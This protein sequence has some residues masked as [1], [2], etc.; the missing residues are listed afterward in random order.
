VGL[1]YQLTGSQNWGTVLRG[2]FGVFYDLVSSETGTALAFPPFGALK[3]FRSS[4]PFGAAGSAPPVIPGTGTLPLLFAFNPN[5][6]LPYTLEWNFAV[7]QGLGRQQMIS[8][9]YIGAS[10]RRLLQTTQVFAPPS[11]PTVGSAGGAAFVDNTAFSS[12]NTLQVQFQ[13]RLSHGLQVLA[14]YGWAHSID[15]GSAGSVQLPSNKGVP[16]SSANANRGS[17][18]FDI[19]HTFSAGVTYDISVP[20]MN[21]FSDAVLRGWSLQSMVLARSAPPVD[22]SDSNFLQLSN[23]ASVDIRPDIIPG[24]SFYLYGA[25]CASVMQA[26]KSIR[27]GRGCPGGKGINPNAFQDPPSDPVTG[28]PLRQG[29]VPRNFL[30]GFGATQWDFAIHREFPIRESVKLQFRAEMFNLLNHPNFGPPISSWPFNFGISKKTL[31]QFLDGGGGASN[32]GGGAFSSLYQ[33][34]GPRSIQ[35]ALKLFF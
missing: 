6:K 14:S 20:R 27:P 8:T 33:V 3:S 16:G 11:N 7:E 4:F 19:R 17:S 9:S 24:Q 23:G 30:R 31:G 26:L 28:N 25:S 29:N 10:G 5:L 32:V 13:R 18:D 2:G 15:N 1:A 12:Y 34:G 22:I 21:T 35:L